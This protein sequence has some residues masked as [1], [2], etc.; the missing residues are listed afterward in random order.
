L[1][2]QGRRFHTLSGSEFKANYF[3]CEN[4]EHYWISGCKKRGG[5][6]LYAGTIEIDNDVR[7][8]YGTKSVSCRT[9]KTK[10]DFAA[11]ESATENITQFQLA[12]DEST[13]NSP[14]WCAVIPR[15]TFFG[16]ARS[17][18]QESPH[19]A[20]VR[21]LVRAGP[22]RNPELDADDSQSAEP[23]PCDY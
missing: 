19:S 3:D 13:A 20:M 12:C 8:E 6:R 21:L 4:G 15:A 17:T 11:Q 1:Y 9:G 10:S 16:S 7:E 5:D 23:V 18:R 2:Y 22:F 14:K